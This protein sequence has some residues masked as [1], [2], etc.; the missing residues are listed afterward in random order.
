MIKFFRK[1]RKQLLTENKF[2]KYLMYAIGEI[3]LVIIGILI[4]LYINNK[5]EIA[6]NEDKFL[7]NLILVHNELEH[8][9]QGTTSNLD[10]YLKKDSLIHS[11]MAD[12]LTIEDY[13][14]THIGKENT[15]EGLG[16]SYIIFNT[17]KA[18]IL[19]NSFNKLSQS[20]DKLPE[21]Y[22]PIIQDLEKVY[23]Q[24]R[25][26][27]IDWNNKMQSLE[28]ENVAKFSDRYVWFSKLYF[29]AKPNNDAFNFFI[30]DPIYKNYVSQYYF[31]LKEQRDHIQAF[32]IEATKSYFAITKLLKLESEFT[33][34][35]SNFNIKK[36]VLLCYEGRYSNKSGETF[37]IVVDE[38]SLFVVDYGTKSELISLSSTKF[39][40][41]NALF[42]FTNPS[43][44]DD[45]GFVFH[46][47]GQAF[48]YTKNE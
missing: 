33:L 31:L 28:N 40:V 8:N 24:H 41:Q 30:E 23:S 46:I 19:N 36:E 5:N 18:T 22:Y 3:V 7:S 1:I 16:L 34:E 10:Y 25:T 12:T 42:T 20:T 47:N 2:S 11:I 4:A 15:E 9:I 35:G 39:M 48:H 14:K 21:E 32:R 37:E 26:A 45:P 17:T 27:V 6:K 44:C 13:S 43:N 38:N 29:F